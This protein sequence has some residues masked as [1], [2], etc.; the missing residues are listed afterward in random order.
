MMLLKRQVQTFWVFWELQSS[1]G[2]K[3]TS[4]NDIREPRRSDGT[5]MN[6]VAICRKN[7]STFS[8]VKYA[9]MTLPKGMSGVQPTN[10]L[11]VKTFICDIFDRVV[12]GFRQ[13]YNP[14]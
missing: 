8:Y 9:L 3:Q 4:R 13:M 10:R 14:T 11:V 2:T 5:G 6:I 12:A 1:L 7:V